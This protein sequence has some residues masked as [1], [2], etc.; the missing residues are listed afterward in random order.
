[1]KS[2]IIA[3][4]ALVSLASATASIDGIQ[5]KAMQPALVPRSENAAFQIRGKLKSSLQKLFRRDCDQNTGETT[6]SCGPGQQVICNHQ[7]GRYECKITNGGAACEA[8]GG[9]GSNWYTDSQGNTCCPFPCSQE[10]VD[11]CED[12][13]KGNQEK[14]DCN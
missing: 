7:T 5:F 9:M 11:G 8:A 4:A 12:A 1:M 14:K 6:L 3:I 13:N 2:A 10:G